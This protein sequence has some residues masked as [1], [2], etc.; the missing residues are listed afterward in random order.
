MQLDYGSDFGSVTSGMAGF[1]PAEP[2]GS[3]ELARAQFIG[4]APWDRV[5]LPFGEIQNLLG[6]FSEQTGAQF[7]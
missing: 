7:G 6:N 4:E 2:A 3:P 1:S 5:E